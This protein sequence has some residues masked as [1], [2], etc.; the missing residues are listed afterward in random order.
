MDKSSANYWSCLKHWEKYPVVTWTV[1]ILGLLLLVWLAFLRN[2]GNIGLIDETEPLFA[3]AA[4]Q[5][6]VTGDWITPYFNDDTR[7]D[8]PP[9]IY[10]LMAIAYQLIGV[11]EWTVRLPSALAA[12]ALT[13]SIFYTLLT[14]GQS[15]KQLNPK[16]VWLSTWL[17]T[18]TSILNLHSIAWGRIGVSDMLLNGCMGSALLAFFL[19]YASD[20]PQVKVRW[21]FA[22]YLLIV[23]AVLTKGPVGIVLPALIIGSFLLYLGNGR[24]VFREMPWQ[25][26]T[27]TIAIGTL[28][29]YVLVTRANGF[30]YIESFFGYHNLER[31]TSVVN[32][33]SAPW[34]FYVLAVLVGFIPWSIYLPVAIAKTKF[35]QRR[36]W[37][38]Q[39]RTQHLSLFAFFWFTC[40]FGFFT[41]AVTKLPSYVLPLM[42]A[43][44]LLIAHL[45]YLPNDRRSQGFK[46]AL[47]LT[48]IINVLLGL[49]LGGAVLY[50]PYWLGDDPAMPHFPE[51]LQ[52]SGL[53]WHSALIF[54]GAALTG[55]LLLLTRKQAWVWAVNLLAFVAI[56]SWVFIPLSTL[57]DQQRQLPLRQ[58][59]RT[60]VEVRQPG[61]RLVTIGFEKPSLVFYTQQR[62]RFYLRSTQAVRR[63]KKLAIEKPDLATVLILGHPENIT[64]T[65]LQTH[66]YEDFGTAKP[67]Q[68]IRVSRQEILNLK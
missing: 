54:T 35:W 9:L 34:Y 47:N 36:L 41:I 68:L 29:W 20:K 64:E 43:S 10:W 37:Q 40:I 51:A 8:K 6:T 5:M 15:H 7:F 4:R 66:H 13:C 45:V 63:L 59:A 21:Y 1:S 25:L 39:P 11:N 2:L 65:G 19:G 22:F 60:I 31:F 55:I 3:E 57:V 16:Q 62:V 23:L 53:L 58:F 32:H 50:S 46:L 42:P 48:S 44:A 56:L 18:T 26:G 61:E 28:P 30:D 17:G 67:Y 38:H 33:H 24:E 49:V 14:I 52:Q 12:I 27:F